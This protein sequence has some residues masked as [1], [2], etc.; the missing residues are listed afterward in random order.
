MYCNVDD[1]FG[2]TI[3]NLPDLLHLDLTLS[4]K[5][6]MPEEMK[7]RLTWLIESRGGQFVINYTDA[8]ALMDEPMLEYDSS[9]GEDDWDDSEEDQDQE[10]GD[11]GSPEERD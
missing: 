4:L 7:D 10:D 3:E 9:D 6:P 2:S 8:F 1:V 5:C 11:Q